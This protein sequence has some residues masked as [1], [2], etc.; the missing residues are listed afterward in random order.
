MKTIITF[1]RKIQ[2]NN[3]LVFQAF[4]IIIL[5]VGK[6][7]PSQYPLQPINYYFTKIKHDKKGKGSTHN[8]FI[9]GITNNYTENI[10]WEI[11]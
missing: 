10:K 3:K 6:Q 7:S 4:F 2:A 9:F 8:Y 11:G 5:H 1:E